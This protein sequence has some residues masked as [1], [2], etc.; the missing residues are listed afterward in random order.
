MP[1]STSDATVFGSGP[2]A[3]QR[4]FVEVDADETCPFDFSDDPGVVLFFISWA[5]SVRFG[6]THELARA[7]TQLESGHAIDLKPLR[8]YA[9]RVVRD[10]ADR[11]ELERA[12]Q[13]AA[14]LA[15]SCRAVADALGS[16]D[17][18]LRELTADY[19]QLA[20]RLHELAAICD[21][22]T[23][24]E[25]RVRLSFDL[26]HVEPRAARPAP[27]EHSPPTGPPGRP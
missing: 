10:E 27:P 4:L 2:A 5:Y 26:G 6:G 15:T 22:A 3:E 18:R 11:Q 7:A 12:W 17:D 23:E 20:P 1:R 19:T 16:D 13:P 25:A 9:D 8:R 14:P 21:W 24:R